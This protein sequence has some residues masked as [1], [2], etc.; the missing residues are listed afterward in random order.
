MG[1]DVADD[2]GPEELIAPDRRS[3][4]GRLR[5]DLAVGGLVLTVVLLL[6]RHS[7]HDGSRAPGPSAAPQ[8]AAHPFGTE[9]LALYPVPNRRAGNAARCP[10][11]FQCVS[12][13]RATSAADAALR[14]AFPGAR[15]VS[16]HTVRIFVQ[17]YGQA[18][19]TAHVRA[20]DGDQLLQLRLQPRSPNDGERHDSMLFD[21]RAITHWESVLLQLRVVIA[22]VAPADH[23]V[24][25]GAVEQLAR[26]PRLLS[27][28]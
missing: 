8:S 12:S 26:D 18:L 2:D 17:G 21:G 20:R 15:I 5:V 7:G 3:R 1:S 16:A 9:T 19:W 13:S 24:S 22:V 6:T 11:G 10:A 23:P 25:L 14:D 27:S 28:W 4:V